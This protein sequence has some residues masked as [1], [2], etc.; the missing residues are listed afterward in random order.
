VAARPALAI[1]RSTFR[2]CVRACPPPDDPIE[3]VDPIACKADAK[4]VALECKA[5]CREQRQ[6]QRDLCLN[7]D[8]VCV[9]A[10]RAGRDACRTPIEDGL[11]AA[12][13]AAFRCRDAAREAA[14]PLFES[15]G[16]GFHGC[17]EACPAAS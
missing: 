6:I 13:V 9:E 5:G 7:R 4:M 17:A 3:I 12:Y 11:D 15:C 10:C 16:A 8:H 1:C 2:D 14:R